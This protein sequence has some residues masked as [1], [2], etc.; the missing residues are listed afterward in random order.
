MRHG[1][2]KLPRGVAW[3]LCVY[4]EGDDVLHLRQNGR[5]ADDERKTFA[6]AAA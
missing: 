6:V 5:R 2:D 1:T 3:Q 4:V